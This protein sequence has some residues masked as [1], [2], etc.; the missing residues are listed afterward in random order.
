M[1]AFP[2]KYWRRK[3]NSWGSRGD[4]F[5]QKRRL[6]FGTGRAYSVQ[7]GGRGSGGKNSLFHRIFSFLKNGSWAKKLLKFGVAAAL[8]AMLFGT[9]FFIYFSRD[10]PSPDKLN[11]RIVT[12]STKIYD[13][14]GQQ[15]YD[16]F[17]EVKRTLVP[18]EEIPQHVKDATV[19][20]EDKDFYKHSGIDFTRILSTAII[21]TLTLSKKQGASTITQQFIRNA[22]L[23]REKRWSRKIKEIVL[24][25]QIERK[26]S[27]DQILSLYLNEI[28]YGSNAYGVQAAAQSYFNKNA[29][30]LTLAEAAYVAA[31]PQSP[32][33]LSP[34]GPHRDRLDDRKNLT[35][36]LM[37]D[38][39]YINEEEM[40]A[41]QAEKVAFSPVRNSIKAPHFVLYIADLLAQKY[42][43]TSLQE[44]G[45][46][47][48]T[49]LDW[50]LQQAAE[51]AV[52]EFAPKNA[53]KYSANNAALV[54]LDPLTG[55]ILAMV[56]S[57]NYFDDAIDGQVNVALRPRQPGSSFKPYVYATA[58]KKGYSPASMLMDVTTNFGEFGDSD[59]TPKNYSGK[60][61]GPISMRQALA[62]S[63]NIPAVKTILLAGVKDSI[64]MAH[65]LGITTLTDE[66]RYGPSLVLGGGEVT[67]LDH[68]SAF[69]TFA[70][71]GVRKPPV[72]ILKITD[73]EGNVL[74]EY[75]DKE[76]Q[77]VLDPQIA[78]LITS[79]LSDNGARSFIFGARSFLVLPDRPVAAKT[80]TTQEFHDG[81]TMGYTP[82]L[83]VGVW[84]GNNNNDAM[85]P[86]AD[87]SVVAAPI[88]NAFMKKAHEGKPAMQF[89]RPVDIRDLAVDKLSGKLPT[90]FTPETK[91]EI[92]A[93]FALPQTYDDVHV[94][95][96]L[97]KNTLAPAD[98]NTPP[99]NVVIRMYTIL[100]S[101]KP[102]DAAWENPVREWAQA[103]GY[104][105]PE[106]Y[107]GMPGSQ[108]GAPTFITLTQ[109]AEGQTVTSLPLTIEAIAASSAGIKQIAFYLDGKEILKHDSAAAKL[110]YSQPQS[111]GEHTLT[112]TAEDSNGNKSSVTR[113]ITFKLADQKLLLLAPNSGDAISFPL[114][115]TARG[116]LNST[117]VKFYYRKPG[118]EA[119]LVPG[120]VLRQNQ[121]NSAD[122]NL[123]WA[124]DD[125]PGPGTYE[126]FAGNS[127]GEQS[128]VASVTIP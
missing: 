88:W 102:N 127:S 87:G 114:R 61:Y 117:E 50:S 60:N 9:A 41:A 27:K 125:K 95:I 64:D 94:P 65:D 83:A 10:L 7:F 5:N 68:T 106:G 91:P 90:E 15:L 13:R 77:Q 54:A 36:R 78:Y 28:P 110:F 128:N 48:T 35:L 30:D 122:F 74:E 119:T 33:T 31:L 20:I 82:Q 96:K 47:V 92:F 103:N 19:A 99:G 59:Y 113:K 39:G 37:R 22:L 79:I 6:L 115:L 89:K 63:L 46:Q 56:G 3:K 118:Q 38:Q 93:S 25:V 100:H 44:S 73:A 126:I 43:E 70:N 76:G 57:K 49:T 67:P 32:T 71:G 55:Q 101:E 66:S 85:K 98:E 111:D 11:A 34:Y 18:F 14:N 58:F 121:D 42:G 123:I 4:Y 40:K 109:P 23:T 8:V 81:W 84:V 62:G 29:K 12:Q 72:G 108:N 2:Q 16:I 53:E 97:D 69:A 26:Y 21:D 80:G 120:P 86:G 112:V 104:P 24:A 52:A 17:G 75:Q 124:E 1:T 105:Y 51:N 45:L 107:T 116:S